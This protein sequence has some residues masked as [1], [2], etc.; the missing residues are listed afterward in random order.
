MSGKNTNSKMS[1]K[2]TKSKVSGKNNTTFNEMS[3]LDADY[4][5]HRSFWLD[6]K[7]I[8]MTIPSIIQLVLQSSS[9]TQP[10]S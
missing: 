6:A 10:N 5:Q 4:V 1:D 9:E 3:Q 8:A 2:N 7:I